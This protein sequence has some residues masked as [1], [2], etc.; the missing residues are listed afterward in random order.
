MSIGRKVNDE[1][2]S[3]PRSERLAQIRRASFATGGEQRQT[4]TDSKGEG[5]GAQNGIKNNTTWNKRYYILKKK[6]S[7]MSKR[8]AEDRKQIQEQDSRSRRGKDSSRVGEYRMGAQQLTCGRESGS[9]G[10]HGRRFGGKKQETVGRG[11][12]Y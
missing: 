8:I 9:T 1:A 5:A 12:F 11:G 3:G 7:K 4:A 10:N 2:S 6:K